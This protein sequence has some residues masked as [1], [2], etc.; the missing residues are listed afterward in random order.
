MRRLPQLLTLASLALAA[1]LARAD[2]AGGG[3]EIYAVRG[4]TAGSLLG[5]LGRGARVDLA[6]LQQGIPGARALAWGKEVTHYESYSP[7]EYGMMDSTTLR[8]GNNLLYL[9]VPRGMV[10]RAEKMMQGYS[11]KKMPGGKVELRLE[12]KTPGRSLTR[13]VSIPASQLFHLDRDFAPIR[14]AWTAGGLIQRAGVGSLQNLLSSASR[15]RLRVL[16]PQWRQAGPESGQ[17]AR[18]LHTSR[19]GLTSRIT[20]R[21]T[22]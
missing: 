1:P 21:P 2:G 18:R 14:G 4:Q 10:G 22:R 20:Y 12:L 9:A 19:P 8:E 11:F 13:N 16:T 15:Y 7:G 5:I 17:T 3:F 6:G